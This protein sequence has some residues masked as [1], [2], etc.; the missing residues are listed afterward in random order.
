M[1]YLVINSGSST[2]KIALF[3]ESADGSMQRQLHGLVDRHNVDPTLRMLNE[4][5]EVLVDAPLSTPRGDHGRALE[6]VLDHCDRLFGHDG[7]VAAGHRVV[8]G[9]VKF[10][11]PL[12]IDRSNLAELE[13][14]TPLAPQHQPYNLAGIYALQ[15]LRP[16]LPQIACFD[17]EFHRTIPQVA[18]RFALPREWFEHGVLRYGFHGLSY[19]YI[20]SRLTQIDPDAA[21]GRVVVAHLGHGASVCALSGGV[22]V[23]TSMGFTALDGLPMG[24]RCGNLDPGVV[25]Y[26]MQQKELSASEISFMLYE[27]SGLRGVS[28]I[29]DDMRE[30]LASQAPEAAEAIELF[31]YRAVCEIGALIA[32]LGGVDALVFTGGI[33]EH[34]APVRARILAALGWLGVHVDEASNDANALGISK[35]GSAVRAWVIPTDEELVIAEHCR[36][37]LSE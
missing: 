32:A 14:L 34:A 36:R 6:A 5:G 35:E 20:A 37:I 21:R 1:S 11:T 33:G 9:G 25:L 26:L 12:R 7:L 8:H 10:S 27:R 4:A 19:E 22:S 15:D 31:V 30:L 2:I 23:A 3:S 24:T 28:G 29:S 17:T 16:E 13:A 18:Q